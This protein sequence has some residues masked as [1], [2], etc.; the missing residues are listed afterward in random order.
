MFGGGIYLPD[1]STY[2]PI[3]ILLN[4]YDRS[5]RDELVKI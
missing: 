3:E 4:T 1:P 5:E 2:D